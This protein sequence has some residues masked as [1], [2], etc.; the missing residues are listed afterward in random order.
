MNVQSLKAQGA[1]EFDVLGAPTGLG[2][3]GFWKLWLAPCSKIV[4][5]G[6]KRVSYEMTII[7]FAPRTAIGLLHTIVRS[8]KR[9]I[10]A[11]LA[12]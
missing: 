4:A 7:F 6:G 1:R 8:H 11:K 3:W 10:I 12:Q 2:I 5:L 9:I